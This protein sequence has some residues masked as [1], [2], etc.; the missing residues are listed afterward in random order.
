MENSIKE[1]C[2]E[3]GQFLVEKNRAYGNSAADPLRVFSKVDALEQINVRID[4]KLSRISRGSEYQG[5]D[6]EL[7]LIGYLV[8]KR[9]LRRLA[10]E[11]E[12]VCA[13]LT[14]EEMVAAQ[15]GGKSVAVGGV[16]DGDR[17]VF[18]AVGGCVH[19]GGG[20]VNN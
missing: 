12:P 18:L 19:R 15:R 1:V 13:G 5:D 17:E 3:L 11:K 9:V 16:V 7:D 8:L 10:A 20:F 2:R 4:D 6:T 14:L